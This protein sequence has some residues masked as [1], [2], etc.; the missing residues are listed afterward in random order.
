MAAPRGLLASED[1]YAKDSV[2]KL[3]HDL[4]ENL[5]AKCS[6]LTPASLCVMNYEYDGNPGRVDS[7]ELSR[8]RRDK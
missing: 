1:S 8:S 6:E 3:G 2:Q 4:V 7:T 5:L